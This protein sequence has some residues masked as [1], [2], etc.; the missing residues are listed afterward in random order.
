MGSGFVAKVPFQKEPS[1]DFLCQRLYVLAAGLLAIG[2]EF[3]DGITQ[4]S[5]IIAFENLL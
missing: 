1:N 4:L 5:V 3:C 2:L